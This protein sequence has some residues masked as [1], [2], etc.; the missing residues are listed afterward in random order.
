MTRYRLRPE[1]RLQRDAQGRHILQDPALRRGLR[2]GADDA[3]L[4][5]ALQGRGA[6]VASLVRSLGGGTDATAL[7][8]RLS[9]LARLYLLDGK[10]S[11]ARAALPPPAQ[12]DLAAIA[13]TVPL[14][15]PQGPNPP[16]HR[17]VARGACC[18]SSFLGPM[19]AADRVR[20]EG[21]RMGQRSRVD[22]GTDAIELLVHGGREFAGMARQSGQCVAQGDDGL[23]DV[24]A[25]HG[26]EVKP[27]PCRQ[28]PLRFHRSERGV[29]VSLLLACEAYSEAREAQQE[30]WSAREAEVRS[31]LAEGAVAVPLAWPHELTVGV[32]ETSAAYW[33]T[34]EAMLDAARA[35]ATATGAL[36]AAAAILQQATE[37]RAAALREGP[38]IATPAVLDPLAA[39]LD[40]HFDSTWIGDRVDALRARADDLRQRDEPADA[41]RLARLGEVFASWVD[42]PD[43]AAQCD[44]TATR[45]LHDLVVNDLA[46]AVGLGPLD[47]GLLA[48]GRKVAAA[49]RDA[50]LRAAQAGRATVDGED[51]TLG[52]KLVSRSEVDVAA[53]GEALV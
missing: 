8:R 15:W 52:L 51:A 5:R 26:Y 29:H 32:P 39:C 41:R 34:V 30:P 45:L 46:A 13:A 22:A 3:R 6:D 14:L 35:E 10:R 7:A 31:L 1:L 28:F 48:I 49:E 25:T 17:C 19:T 38:E 4:A 33:A 36:L 37:R 12:P 47:A 18:S 23:C 43:L 27:V 24:H 2:L 11:A 40:G 44:P 21:L 20:V 42:A 9:G 53:L 50:R 16:R